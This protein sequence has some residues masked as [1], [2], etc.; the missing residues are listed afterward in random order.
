MAEFAIGQGHVFPWAPRR[1]VGDPRFRHH[2]ASTEYFIGGVRV[3]HAEFCAA[4]DQR[5]APDPDIE[6][7]RQR[8]AELTRK[9]GAPQ[10]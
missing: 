5:A 3:T 4:V 8:R 6:W 9:Y 1:S 7:L 10:R 2:R